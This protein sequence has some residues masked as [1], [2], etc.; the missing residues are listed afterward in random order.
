MTNPEMVAVGFDKLEKLGVFGPLSTFHKP[1]PVE[2]TFP[3]SV[4]EVR[5]HKLWSTPTVGVVG[6]VEILY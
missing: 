5:P 3:E 2:M 4:V 6:G 1:V